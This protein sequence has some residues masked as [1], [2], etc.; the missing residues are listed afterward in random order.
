MFVVLGVGVS[1]VGGGVSMDE[2]GVVGVDV[3]A[4]GLIVVCCTDGF[5]SSVRPALSAAIIA[6]LMGM[7]EVGLGGWCVLGSTLLFGVVGDSCV[8]PGHILRKLCLLGIKSAS[9]SLTELP[10]LSLSLLNSCAMPSSAIIIE[11]VVSVVVVEL[12]VSVVSSDS[13]LC[14]QHRLTHCR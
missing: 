13:S 6:V 11:A 7:G 1:V 14:H 9:R 10:L 2:L 3:S 4:V 5:V 8:L 12:V